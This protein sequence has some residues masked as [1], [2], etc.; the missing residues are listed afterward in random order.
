MTEKDAPNLCPYCMK[1]IAPD[2]E[3]C[4]ACGNNSGIRLCPNCGEVESKI[5][6]R[7]KKCGYIIKRGTSDEPFFEKYSAQ[8]ITYFVIYLGGLLV[9]YA[10]YR[11]YSRPSAG[12]NIYALQWAFKEIFIAW[13]FIAP[14]ISY[15]IYW[16][17]KQLRG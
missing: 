4:D 15:S 8:I 1:A 16:T 13:T 12:E 2:K 11:Y 9:G 7:C 14:V 17:Y 6:F 3:V 5:G 10:L